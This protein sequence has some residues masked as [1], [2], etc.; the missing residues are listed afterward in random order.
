M[1]TAGKRIFKLR[2]ELGSIV[3]CPKIAKILLH[4]VTL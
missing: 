2:N 3:V 1:D 4:K